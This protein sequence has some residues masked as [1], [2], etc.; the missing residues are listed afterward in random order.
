VKLEDTPVEKNAFRVSTASP[1]PLSLEQLEERVALDGNVHA[2]FAGG[3][4]TIIGDAGDNNIQIGY[5]DMGAGWIR[6]TPLD[7]TTIDG[8]NPTYIEFEGFTGGLALKMGDGNDTVQLIHATVPKNVTW[9]GGNGDDTLSIIDGHIAGAVKADG[10]AGDDTVSLT[11]SGTF[12]AK[13]VSV[14][15]GPGNLTLTMDGSVGNNLSIRGGDGTTGI[16]LHSLT[17]G[18][19]LSIKGAAGYDVETLNDVHVQG[20][21]SINN[22]TGMA[23]VAIQGTI[24]GNVSVTNPGGSEYAYVR[25]TDTTVGR[26][27]SIVNGASLDAYAGFDT[28]SVSGA[29][30]IVNGIHTSAA[31]STFAK[32]LSITNALT[33]AVTMHDGTVSKAFSLKNAAGG[34]LTVAGT[35][36]LCPVTVSNGKGDAHD[37]FTDATLGE[38]SVLHKNYNTSL[39]SS[40]DT[41]TLLIDGC[42]IGGNLSTT[43]SGGEAHLTL[44]NSVVGK[45]LRVTVKGSDSSIDINGLG[46]IHNAVITTGA[47]NDAVTFTGVDAMGALTVKTGAGMDTVSMSSII[48]GGAMKMDTGNDTDAVTI[49]WTATGTSSVFTGP[50]TIKLGT[51]DDDLTIGSFTGGA[52]FHSTVLLDGGPGNNALGLDG[53][54]NTFA[55]TPK[56]IGF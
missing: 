16:S 17:V 8:G 40:G 12:T 1:A 32:G 38:D 36:F 27:V 13:S 35:S 54:L 30:R 6:V 42:T 41:T 28:V 19:S 33:A 50:V 20:N 4:L 45:D 46:I 34:N 2:I 21:I 15:S 11:G 5:S 47:G 44:G 22:G 37:Q 31:D 3:S 7:G 9:S 29:T 14:V 24:D 56:Q 55:V 26:S 43:H 51:G 52:D 18:G 39:K 10:G 49:D 53:R 25:L 48:V 23:S